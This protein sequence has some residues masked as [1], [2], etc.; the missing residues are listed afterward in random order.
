MCGV[1][2]AWGP[3]RIIDQRP[4]GALSK[5]D[6]GW[7]QVGNHPIQLKKGQFPAKKIKGQAY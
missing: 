6:R 7:G 1:K 2:W 5:S 4:L 3:H